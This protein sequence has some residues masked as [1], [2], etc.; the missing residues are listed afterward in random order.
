MKV[1]SRIVLTVVLG[2]SILAGGT[3]LWFYLGI[4]LPS[5]ASLEEYKAAQNSKIYAADGTLLATLHGDQNREMMPLSKIPDHMKNA[6]IAI[7]DTDFFEHSGVN[8]K[9]VVRAL[10]TN[11][12]NREVVQGGSTITQQYVKNA[13]VGAK[14]TLWR[15][16]QEA[17]L[18]YELDRKYSKRKIMEMYLNDI[19]LGQSCY[20]IYT[21]SYKYFGKNPQELSLSECAMLAAVIRSPSYY[22]PFLRPEEV[23]N[24]RNLVLRVM[25]D[26]KFISKGEMEAASAEPMNITSKDQP[27]VERRYP[28]FCDYIIEKMKREYGDQM[29]FRGGLRIYTA[30]DPKLQ[31]IAENTVKNMTN[32]D[33]GPDAALVCLD[34]RTG[35]IK[36]MV[37]GKNYKVSQYNVAADGHR[38]A[39]SSFKTFVLVQA[40]SDGVSPDKTYSSSSPMVIDLPDGQKWKVSNYSGGGGGQI[41]IES[42][43]IRSV[44]VVY[45]Q[46]IMDL[47][48]ARV[49]SMAKKMG[50]MTEIDSNPAIA[51]GGL[52]IGVTPLEMASA[53]GTLANSG[54][55]AVP[56]SVIKI[57]DADGKVIE[58]NKPEVKGAI[59][60]EVSFEAN[61]ILQKVV[62]SGTGTG[63]NI[64]RPQA[65]KTGTTE[66][67]ADAWF[68]G[69]TPDLVTAVWVGYPQGRISMGGMTGGN[70]PASIWRSFMSKALEDVP[71]TAFLEPGEE[72]PDEEQVADQDE[73]ATITVVICDDSGLIATSNC[74]HTHS[75][76]FERGAAPTQ[77]CN[78]HTEKQTTS[79]PNVV[80][81]SSSGARSTLAAAGYS[82]T[83]VSQPSSKPAGTVVSQVPAPGTSLSKGGSV[84]IMVST[85]EV[86]NTVPSVVGLSESAAIAKLSGAGFVASV[87]YV[88]GSPPGIVTGQRPSSGTQLS[89]G[90]SVSITVNKSGT[91][92]GLF[93]FILSLFQ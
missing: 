27:I 79:V 84:T 38:Q 41:T 6:V 76:S 45:A 32:P 23:K 37:G 73:S 19:Y 48:P 52:T 24:R 49:A 26:Q 8:W 58:E 30:L 60:S 53:Y 43:T 15:K 50:I 70:L 46:M 55:H 20:G 33:K 71:A 85:G 80:G 12:I 57:T 9:A 4:G 59:S 11:V 56:H 72:P 3:I 25:K 78:I 34:P 54:K 17:R 77:T 31:D 40:L 18:A 68:V 44:N 14:R 69:Y 86:K 67:N 65:G 91:G 74:P 10:W 7:E 88:N 22:D 21:A 28:Y 42:A 92:T 81:M 63:A 2:I 5:L 87:S 16:I 64:G 75:Q 39:G 35:Y 89:P 36:A 61:K 51:L 29:V 90:S 1:I 82:V 66:D 62:S 47:G 93:G 13:Y 83:T